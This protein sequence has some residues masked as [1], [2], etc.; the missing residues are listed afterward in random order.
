[1]VKSMGGVKIYFWTII[2]IVTYPRAWVY[3]L[4]L[5]LVCLT[6]GNPESLGLLLVLSFKVSSFVFIM[7]SFQNPLHTIK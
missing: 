4:T 5:L 7:L 3:L 6:F 2:I 1:M